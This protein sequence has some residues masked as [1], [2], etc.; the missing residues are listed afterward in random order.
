MS[1]LI[2][3]VSLVIIGCFWRQII[4]GGLISLITLLILTL[5][6][7]SFF[8]NNVVAEEKPLAIDKPCSNTYYNQ[9]YL[10]GK[11]IQ[12]LVSNEDL[13][14][15]AE[16]IEEDS[17]P[18]KVEYLLSRNFKEHFDQEWVNKVMQEPSCKTNGWR[19]FML[20]NGQ[21]WYDQWMWS[22]KNPPKEKK[23]VISINY[24][25]RLKKPTKFP[26][27]WIYKNDTLHP[28]CFATNFKN[29]VSPI[30][31]NEC[32]RKKTKFLEIDDGRIFAK[33]KERENFRYSIIK[34]INLG[35]CQSLSEDKYGNCIQSYLI[36]SSYWG[37]GSGTANEVK[38]WGLFD[39][40]N[41]KRKL[42]PIS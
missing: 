25:A 37:G 18:Y 21:I 5:I 32:L 33:D 1:V 28:L 26:K 23:W 19:G 16:L 39:L 15:L 2:I 17:Y 40:E 9:A 31:L 14:G 38:V 7:Y 6:L 22:S 13:E 3:L 41:N 20:G 12:K 35:K 34:E 24:P 30:S 27:G 36:A 8:N 10:F 29:G 4:K 42:I 11:K